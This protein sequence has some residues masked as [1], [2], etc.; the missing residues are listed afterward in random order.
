[1]IPEQRPLLFRPGSE[2]LAVAIVL[3][4]YLMVKSLKQ[5][6][7]IALVTVSFGEECSKVWKIGESAGILIFTLYSLQQ[8]L[9]L[10]VSHLTHMRRCS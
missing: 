1:M 10:L 3:G 4:S 2:C 5:H 9:T 7:K 6:F 8:I